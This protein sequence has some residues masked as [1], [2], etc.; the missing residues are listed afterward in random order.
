MVGNYRGISLL[1][2]WYK[3]YTEILRS[4]LEKEIEEKKLIPE[5]QGGFRKA[6]G[7][8]DNVYVLNHLVQREE[9]KDKK[10]RKV[11]AP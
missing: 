3:I 7:V 10:E 4:R 11:Y 2:T 1:S 9:R 5:S 6:R 8:M